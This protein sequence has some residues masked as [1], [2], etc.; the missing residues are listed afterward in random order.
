MRYEGCIQ[1]VGF[2]QVAIEERGLTLAEAKRRVQLDPEQYKC[3]YVESMKFETWESG[4]T[5]TEDDE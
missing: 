3:G 2:I 1:I 4:P 5:K